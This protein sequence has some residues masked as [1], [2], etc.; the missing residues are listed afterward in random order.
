MPASRTVV[1]AGAGIGGLTAGLALA[2]KG[3]R[4]VVF[5]SAERLE[6]V[7][8]GIQLSLPMRRAFSRRW[9]STNG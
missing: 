7:G 4:V 1:I 9:A 6:E 2:R 8:A 5:E 3:F